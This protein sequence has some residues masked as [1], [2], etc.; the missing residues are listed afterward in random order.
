MII[1]LMKKY[2]L[3][4]IP[5]KA[6]WSV[7]ILFAFFKTAAQNPNG[8]ITIKPG[9]ALTVGKNATLVT[10][11]N[12]NNSGTLTNAGS[13]ILNGN[14]V[15]TFPG[16]AGSIPLMSLLEVKNTGAGIVLNQSIRIDKELKLTNGN[17]ALGNYDI[18]IKSNAA[19]TAAVSAIA[20]GAG[21]SYDTGRFIIERFINVG[22]AGHGKSWQFLSVPATGKTIKDSWQEAGVGS[23]GYGTQLSNPLGVAAGY[24]L[25]TPVTSIKTYISTTNSYD[26][27]PSSTS[28]LI[29]NLKGYMLF[30]RGDR[31]VASGTGTSPT[32]LRIKGTLFTP[33]NPPSSI[34]IDSAKFES[35]GNPYASQIDFTLLNTTGGVDSTF[36]TWDP[37]LIGSYGVGGYQTIIATNAWNA[38]PGGGN[39]AG[40]HKNIESGQAFFVHSTAAQGTLSFTENV[41]TGGST[42]LNRTASQARVTTTRQYLRTTLLT[43]TGL[44][45]DGNAAVFASD[46]SNDV[47][48]DDAIKIMN[49]G[50]NFCLKR[51]NNSLAVEG[52]SLITTTDTLFYF[53]NHLLQQA[54]T[55]LIVPENMDLNKQAWL[56]DNFLQ[57]QTTVSLSSSSYITF[58]VTNDP[59][60]YQSNR[61]M[62][63]FKPLTVL[64]VSAITLNAVRNV[65]GTINI[66]W[67]ATI[68]NNIREYIV[69]KSADA[70]TF[71]TIHTKN[72]L[73]NNGSNANYFFKDMLPFDGDNFYR[74]KITTLNGTVK[75]SKVVKVGPIKNVEEINVYP[76][77]VTGR[78]LNLYFANLSFGN[79][80]IVLINEAGQQVWTSKI[81]FSYSSGGKIKLELPT[82]VAAGKYYLSLLDKD[83]RSFKITLMLL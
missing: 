42:L 30:V 57:T 10:N 66:K 47:N 45:A 37:T 64:G 43:N 62:L 58:N 49:G 59:L 48:S 7:L 12:I 51:S 35:V 31:T 5:G 41:K 25:Y 9:V 77:P 20:A 68:E 26:Q 33:A 22:T 28:A 44:I 23:V 29:N 11:T 70:I 16:T 52:R 69:E 3:L 83:G 72:A 73:I 13:I 21:V 14:T 53:T 82:N 55:I 32:T 65:D 54:Y 36:Y 19:Q 34:T 8:I 2:K 78:S 71:Y 79:Y 6:L 4:Q 17:L 40:V 61:F 46:L 63:V 56:V 1:E 50:E 74:I 18:T 27:G 24:D 80:D 15:Q 39:Y 81:L 67:Q 38:V 76:N 60:S 75:Y